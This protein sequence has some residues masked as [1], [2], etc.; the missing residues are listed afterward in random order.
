[1][2]AY[3]GNGRSGFIKKKQQLNVF[4][5]KHKGIMFELKCVCFGISEMSQL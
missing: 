2:T 1:M 5:G 3:G 4:Y